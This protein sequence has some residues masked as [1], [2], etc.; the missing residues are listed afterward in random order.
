[1]NKSFFT[2]IFTV[3]C[4]LFL[5]FGCKDEELL[6]SK[7][8]YTGNEIRIDGYYYLQENKQTWIRFFYRDGV[9][10]VFN[11]GFP[12]TNLDAVDAKIAEEY[13]KYKNDK[14]SWGVFSVA[15]SVIQYSKWGPS[16]GGGLTSN[17]CM[18]TIENDTTFCLIKSIYYTGGIDDFND[19]ERYYFRQFSPK[20]D[21]T[22]NFIK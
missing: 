10:L 4:I 6:L 22:N 16:V 7:I 18:G 11:F 8:P 15:G 1:M 12:I 20:P 2:L 21:S 19:N 9:I 5:F 17:K 3:L 14:L 13:E